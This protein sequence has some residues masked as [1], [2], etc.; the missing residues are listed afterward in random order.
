MIQIVLAYLDNFGM[1]LSG[2]QWYLDIPKLQPIETLNFDQFFT[3]ISIQY[4]QTL[5]IWKEE[6]FNWS[7]PRDIRSFQELQPIEALNFG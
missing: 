5:G 1:V 4:L 3:F 7:A 6:P 2:I